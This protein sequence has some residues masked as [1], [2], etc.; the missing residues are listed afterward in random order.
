MTFENVSLAAVDCFSN[1]ESGIF[2]CF[3]NA[4]PYCHTNQ[5][6]AANAPEEDL[7]P[8]GSYSFRTRARLV[9]IIVIMALAY[10]ARSLT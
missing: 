9:S 10:T 2:C 8:G 7:V 3:K 5:P 6:I 4:Y 1:H